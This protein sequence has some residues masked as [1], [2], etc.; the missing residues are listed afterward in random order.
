MKS[1]RD[2]RLNAIP[3]TDSWAVV[4]KVWYPKHHIWQNLENLKVMSKY[5]MSKTN[6]GWRVVPHLRL[7]KSGRH[8]LSCVSE[9]VEGKLRPLCCLHRNEIT[10]FPTPKQ[11]MYSCSIW[12]LLCMH[13]KTSSNRG[14]SGMLWPG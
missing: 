14:Q 7:D 6:I 2:V 12:R 9:F 1:I 8:D 10:C 11:H 3:P 4:S 13:R 5:Q